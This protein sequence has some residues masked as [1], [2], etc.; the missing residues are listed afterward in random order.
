MNLLL[1]TVTF[2]DSALAPQDI[3]ARARAFI[4]DP[5]NDLYVST[6]SFWEVAIKYSIGKLALPESPDSFLR[7]IREKLG[8]EL[9]PLD[10]ESALHVIR[11]PMLHRDPFDRILICQAIVNGMVFLTSDSRIS[12]YP[13][14]TAW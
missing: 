9:L 5:E 7:K 12:L 4:L 2:L 14:R 6:V 3:S 8:A 10:E 11:L 1:D 13:V